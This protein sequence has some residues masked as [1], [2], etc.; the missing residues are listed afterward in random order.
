[1]GGKG[2]SH[3]DGWAKTS[4][5]LDVDGGESRGRER[6]LSSRRTRIDLCAVV[7]GPSMP[8][9]SMAPPPSLPS[10]E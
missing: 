3:E 7:A 9:W 8:C 10:R 2:S 5:D 4:V 1:M 6:G